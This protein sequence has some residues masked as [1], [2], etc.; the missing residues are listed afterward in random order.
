MLCHDRVRDSGIDGIAREHTLNEISAGDRVQRMAGRAKPLGDCLQRQ[1]FCRV[2][3]VDAPPDCNCW[4]VDSHVDDGGSRKV[5]RR[6]IICTATPCQV[7][8]NK[9]RT[10]TSA[11]DF[12]SND[13][14][15]SVSQKYS[16]PM[17]AS[18]AHPIARQPRRNRN[19]KS[20]WF[21]APVVAEPAM[22]PG[23][24]IDTGNRCCCA[25]QQSCSPTHFDRE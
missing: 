3:Q 22:L 1:W 5:Y 24:M 23:R 14:F 21:C 19:T 17:S 8:D 6:Q 7:V 2:L 18:G 13:V 16:S 12:R 11:L 20:C 9:Y 25:L 4:L 15:V 10:S